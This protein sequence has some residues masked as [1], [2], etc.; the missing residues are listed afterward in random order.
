M[1]GMTG[2]GNAR[3]GDGRLPRRVRRRGGWPLYALALSTL[4]I[5]TGLRAGE[6][7]FDADNDFLTSNPED[8]DLYTFSLAFGWKWGEQT[9]RLR[10]NAFTDKDAGIRFD[11][12]YLTVVRELPLNAGW[13]GSADLG[14]V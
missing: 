5:P 2:P 12:T 1:E 4:L 13:R 7:L 8:D 10:E 11:E 6:I 3:E 14:L 9:L